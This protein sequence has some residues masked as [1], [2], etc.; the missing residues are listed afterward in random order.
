[1]NSTDSL[2]SRPGGESVLRR[3][4][5]LL[6]DF[7]AEAAEVEHLRKMHPADLSHARDRLFM[8]LSGMLGGP[9]LYMQA[10]GHPRLRRRHMHFEIGDVER[11]Q[12]L[13]CARYAADQLEVAPRTRDDLMQ[14]LSVMANHL[15]NKDMTSA[16][17]GLCSVGPD[18]V[19]HNNNTSCNN[20]G[21]TL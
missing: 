17:V 18:D 10:F 1:M 14:E 16:S 21:S 12:W 2:Y 13:Q 11:D 20:S 19:K 15:R 3:Y 7:M 8:F 9:P 5:E 4:V 6:Y